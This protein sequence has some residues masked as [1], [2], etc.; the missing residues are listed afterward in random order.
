MSTT[1][2]RV[3]KVGDTVIATHV[4]HVEEVNGQTVTIT[5][6]TTRTDG[7]TVY[8]ADFQRTPDYKAHY[9]FLDYR[10]PE[11]PPTEPV[12][13]SAL[14]GKWITVVEGAHSPMYNMAYGQVTDTNPSGTI[15]ARVRSYMPYRDFETIVVKT[16]TVLDE[17]PTDT[18]KTDTYHELL[19][20]YLRNQI[21]KA[22]NAFDY[23]GETAASIANDQG[24]CSE[25][26]GVIEELNGSLRRAGYEDF[27]FPPRQQ[28]F[29]L[30]G[31]LVVDMRVPFRATV[32]AS[33]EEDA[34]ELL[35][36]D[37]SAYMYN[38]PE[39]MIIDYG[40]L[41]SVEG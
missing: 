22:V 14:V 37:P 4:P 36:D 12:D 30:E 17:E 24:Y 39:D 10:W 5:E 1:E 26:D 11:E 7:R 29:E 15:V 18:R 13:N 35:S 40:L 32:T 6:I 3:P 20:K 25:Y 27:Q 38:S 34:W 28:D 33:S 9:Y 2:V 8:Y 41:Y 21:I 19:V 31:Y 16:W 23:A